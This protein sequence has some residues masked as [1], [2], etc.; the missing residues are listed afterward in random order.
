MQIWRKETKRS[1]LEDNVVVYIDKSEGMH[2]ENILELLSEF[3]KVT[4][5]KVN[6]QKL[7]A[8]NTSHVNFRSVGASNI[9]VVLSKL[10]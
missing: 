4:R 3:C 1:L 8:E 9:S 6:I 5:Y 10:K 7:I 2:R